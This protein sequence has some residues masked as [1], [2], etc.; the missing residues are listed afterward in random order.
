MKSHIQKHETSQ[1]KIH[2]RGDGPS[3]KQGRFKQ[4]KDFKKDYKLDLERK[5]NGIKSYIQDSYGSV[6]S[7]VR[8]TTLNFNNN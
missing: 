8:L 2:T 3:E 4:R 6:S 7:D 1:T 5:E